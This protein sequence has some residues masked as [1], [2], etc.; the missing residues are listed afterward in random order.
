MRRQ[1]R[2]SPT[3]D[4]FTGVWEPELLSA[5]DEPGTYRFSCPT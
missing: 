4:I 3:A 5:L 1:S 2:V